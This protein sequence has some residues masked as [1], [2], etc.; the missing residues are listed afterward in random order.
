MGYDN[1]IH[2][3]FLVIHLFPPIMNG[4]GGLFALRKMYTSG[5]IIIGIMISGSE[6]II[7]PPNVPIPIV[8]MVQGMAVNTRMPSSLHIP[9]L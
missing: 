6:P 9:S 8:I 1:L 2:S 4:F 3:D 5:A 7:A